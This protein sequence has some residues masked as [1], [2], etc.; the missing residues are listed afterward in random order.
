MRGPKRHLGEESE[1]EDVEDAVGSNGDEL[2]AI[3]GLP[4][5]RFHAHEQ[6]FRGILHGHEFFAY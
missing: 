6:R 2:V 1:A 5:L 4:L 3:E